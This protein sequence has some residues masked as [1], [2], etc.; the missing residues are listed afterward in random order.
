MSANPREN[1]IPEDIDLMPVVPANTD[2]GTDYFRDKVE[3][4]IAPADEIRFLRDEVIG[5][6][7]MSKV[8]ELVTFLD[9]S[10]AL[11]PELVKEVY[12][13]L[14]QQSPVMLRL[15]LSF[16]KASDANVYLLQ[17]ALSHRDGAIRLAAKRCFE[18]MEREAWEARRKK[19]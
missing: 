10:F 11:E 15:V 8:Y 13:E 12:A 17:K 7:D 1:P 5:A 2:L 6:G 14:F 16:L 3:G 9:Q 4:V 19:K 18:D